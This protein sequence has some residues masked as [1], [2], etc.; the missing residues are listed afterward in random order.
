MTQ[1]LLAIYN[2]A[3]LVALPFLKRSARVSLGWKQRTLQE[4]P[5]GPFDLW[6]QSA[7][8][9]ESLLTNMVL[10]EL[11]AGLLQGKVLRVLA[12]SGTQ[13]GID[14]L[15]KGCRD[16]GEHS[17]L[18]TTVAY[19]P[20]DAPAI[21]RKAFARF[22]P[23]LAV[24]VETELWPGFLCHA[25]K[26]RIPV[27]LINGRMSAKSFR[28]FSYFRRFFHTYRPDRI[29]AISPE[30]GERFSQIM[31]STAI[32]LMNNI[33]F[34]R[35]TPAAGTPHHAAIS[36]LLPRDVPF[37]L[38]GS[39]RREEEKSI[40]AAVRR[41]LNSGTEMVIGIFPKHIERADSWL[42]G[43]QAEGIAA[44]RRS[45]AAGAC[46]AGSVIVWDVFGELADAYGLAKTTFIGGSLVNSGG[47]N[48]LEPLAFGVKPLIGPYW[49]DFSWVSREIISSG[50][51]TEVHSE[52]ELCEKLLAA[53]AT[54][55]DREQIIEQV[56]RFL[57][58]RKGGSCQASRQI[59][60]YLQAATHRE[61]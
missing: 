25:R 56:Q 19:F 36:A 44:I 35:I 22:R 40:A 17:P 27:L 9:G 20:F 52:Q 23:G 49:S 37:V 54:E 12:T 48:F 31:G 7:S 24:I 30:D 34:D 16:R 58:T 15:L 42:A 1:I 3:W 43:L 53:L 46:R 39:I 60:N 29:W 6:I 28:S 5:A 8:G 10:A 4:S 57:I 11:A 55:D 33:K 18:A 47:Q 45:S 51:V 41:L 59:L 14:S 32:E 13:Q 26:E 21:M 38:F 50:L 2:L 61:A